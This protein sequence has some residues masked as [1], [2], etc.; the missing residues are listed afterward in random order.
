MEQDQD[1]FSNT[2]TVKRQAGK[3]YIPAQRFSQ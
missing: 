1:Y 3:V 2:A